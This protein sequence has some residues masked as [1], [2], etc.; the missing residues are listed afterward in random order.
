MQ[1]MLDSLRKLHNYDISPLAPAALII[2]ALACAGRAIYAWI[3]AAQWAGYSHQLEFGEGFSTYIAQLWQTGQFNWDISQ[4]PYMTLIY[5]IIHPIVLSP[6]LNW[7]DNPLVAGRIL[8]IIATIIIALFMFL[9]AQHL[10]KNKLLGII[11]ALL[12]FAA[13]AYRDWMFMARC[14]MIAI[15]FSIIGLY[16]AIKWANSR[17][18]YLSILFF[19][20][21]FFTKQ[22]ILTAFAAVALFTFITN[23][24]RGLIY[25]GISV[26]TI[27]TGIITGNL[28]TE[29]QF[30]NQFFTYNQTDPLF[31]DLGQVA[32]HVSWILPALMPSIAVASAYSFSKI[33]ELPALWWLI[34]MATFAVFIW[35][36][37]GYINYGL[38]LTLST[39]LCAVIFL[40]ER[41][42]DK[43]KTLL[44]CLI[45]G[46]QLAFLCSGHP[47]TTPD[48]EYNNRVETAKAIIADANYPI[49]TENAGLLLEAG[50]EPYYECFVFTNLQA[51]GYWNENIVIN[52][53]ETGKIP[54]IVTHS[55][56]SPETNS[57]TGHFSSNV[58]NTILENYHIVYNPNGGT[59][60]YPIIVYKANEK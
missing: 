42:K 37:G 13:P 14:D 38:E 21:A 51:L 16:I 10:T 35:R 41:I 55:I 23:H 57:P 22:N 46:L 27:G 19:V 34:S 2:I 56:L 12:P 28:L 48:E 52:N 6:M 58:L 20:L 29:G 53:L 8:S 9:I 47:I 33:K 54:Y 36:E 18:F 25:G 5:G 31:W 24:K 3:Y 32:S 39:S 17:W 4:Q 49:L 50:K 7:F 30:W 11:V 26:I 45:I 60:W 43:N 40:K 1:R 44:W 15:M 59:Y